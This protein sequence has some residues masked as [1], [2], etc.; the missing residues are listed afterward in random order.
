MGERIVTLCTAQ[1]ADL[2]F[3][4]LCKT[5]V[6]MGYDGIEIATWGNSFDIEKACADQNYIQ[7]IRDTLKKNN[8]NVAL[9][10]PP[11]TGRTGT[12]FWVCL[13]CCMSRCISLARTR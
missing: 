2:S 4:E 3:E 13:F 1:W 9:P 5:A 11:K 8:L 6:S 12:R 10:S 7:F